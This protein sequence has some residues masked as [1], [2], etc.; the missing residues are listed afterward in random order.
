MLNIFLVSYFVFI[1]LRTYSQH[2]NSVLSILN[3]RMSVTERKTAIVCEIF[4][5]EF[6]LWEHKKYNAERVCPTMN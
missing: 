2:R 1:E 4:F 6:G 5:N 3:L